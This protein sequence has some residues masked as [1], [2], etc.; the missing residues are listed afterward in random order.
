M[1]PAPATV[2]ISGDFPGNTLDALADTCTLLR[3]K[4]RPPRPNELARA[5]AWICP[6]TQRV[7]AAALDHAPRLR[8]VANYAVGFDNV[9]VAACT[10]RGV[11]VTNTPGVLTEATA[12]LTLA[13]L[14][15]VARRI[16]EADALVRGGRWT[17]FSP[18][19]L[20]GS[21]LQ[22]KHLGLVGLGRIG[23][24]VARRAAAFGM[25]L[26]YWSP[27]RADP[28]TETALGISYRGWG[29]LLA[30]ADVLSLHCPLRPETRGLLSREALARLPAGA[31]VINTAR[32]ELL[33]TEALVDALARGHLRGAGLDVFAGE[34]AVDPRLAALPQVV[35]SPHIGSATHEA[36][37]GMARLC[38]EAVRALWRGETPRHA[39]NPEALPARGDVR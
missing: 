19:L 7:D 12:D 10:A 39:L 4:G 5:W 1:Q 17:G 27:R 9:D 8:L 32:G 6:L 16:P 14:L 22:G 36:R 20:L 11:L 18:T 30:G 26:R 28:A 13:L 37:E 15:S 31:I 34:P 21:S 25:E 29:E 3:T 24:A 23:R 38:A 2:L 33:D 35:L